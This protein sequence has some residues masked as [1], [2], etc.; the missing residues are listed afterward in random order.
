[1]F[2][3][4]KGNKIDNNQKETKIV[5]IWDARLN[6]QFKSVST[7]SSTRETH[8]HVLFTYYGTPYTNASLWWKRN[9]CCPCNTMVVSGNFI[10][11]YKSNP[12]HLL[13]AIHFALLGILHQFPFLRCNPLVELLWNIEFQS[14]VAN[15]CDVTNR[16]INS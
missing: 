10:S 9:I 2:R 12:L 16:V 15:K 4:K 13:M 6:I 11:L 1:M 3:E 14:G 8:F 7:P 5:D